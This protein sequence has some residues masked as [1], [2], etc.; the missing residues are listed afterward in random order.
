MV[1]V[2]G[3]INP[4]ASH[5]THVGYRTSGFSSATLRR[6]TACVSRHWRPATLFIL[7][8][9]LTAG[10]AASRPFIYYHD[11]DPLT[12]FRKAWF[13][14]GRAGGVDVASRGIGYPFWLIITG[15]AGFDTWWGLLGSQVAMAVLMPVL[16]YAIVMPISRNAGM[17][18]GLLFI[19]FGIPYLHMN[20]A[21]TEQLFL[22]MELLSFVLIAWYLCSAWPDLEA[23][24]HYTGRLAR[25]AYWFRIFLRS[26]YAIALLLAYTTMVKP[27]ASPIFWIFLAL[28]LLF[29]IGRWTR[30]FGP[31]VLYA[32][33]MTGW[34]TF[35]YYY[36]SARF[37]TLATPWSAAQRV[38]ADTYYGD[39]LSFFS[40][41][42]PNIRPDDGPASLA[43]YR[44]VTQEVVNLRET[45]KWNSN[46]PISVQRL[47]SRFSA[48]EEL[49]AEIFLRPNPLYFTLI[50]KAA[51]TAGGD[52]LLHRV[53]REHWRG[54]PIGLMRY[55]M[56]HPAATLAGPP[57]PYFGY[58]MFSKLIAYGAYRDA[59]IVGVRDVLLPRKPLHLFH[60]DNGPASAHYAASI[61]YFADTLPEFANWRAYETG[62]ADVEAFKQHLI[63]TP[64][65]M[66]TG[67]IYTWLTM[68]Y[69]EQRAGSLLRDVAF[70][71]IQD[72]ALTWAFF[73][74][75]FFAVTA[76]GPDY[77]DEQNQNTPHLWGFFDGFWTEYARAM[78]FDKEIW[79][80]V[81]GRS[82][83]TILPHGLARHLG[84][85][86]RER[87][88]FETTTS[89]V[90][91]LQNMAF[92]WAKPICFFGL[93]IFSTA[94][95]FADI[96]SRIVLF[97]TAVYFA[98][99][100]GLAL[101][102][103]GP[104]GAPRQEEFF[105][106]IPLLIIAV[107]LTALPRLL[108]RIIVGVRS[109]REC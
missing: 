80:Q 57:N 101:V 59:G 32:A 103:I 75:D 48:P 6:L 108:S 68:L 38:F 53:A 39:H 93:L 31:A 78:A 29:R 70:E 3:N 73:I 17:L 22:F 74:G 86:D 44:A 54:E 79:R 64:S 11:S 52:R 30:Y 66:A 107:G 41:T 46:N 13:L 1:T 56:G 27:V 40:A 71:I 92:T 49:V 76:Y 58:M 51:T 82:R 2:N 26:P 87:S 10:Y 24:D 99:A 7:G 5:E 19:T 109:G 43:L 23:Q 89:T 20:W 105:S 47:Y 14:L 85:S 77:A 33:I 9:I 35:D 37:P 83:T 62:L 45:G 95:L 8:V 28:C 65:T 69:G 63:E 98:G 90:L 21:M 16:A 106:F 84:P 60:K 100:S 104:L 67:V 94:L 96:G 72:N 36:G 42:A 34:T 97:L 12:Y 61:H 88:V 102:M 50:V 18:A 4:P 91:F 55:L 81:E 25:A 15:A